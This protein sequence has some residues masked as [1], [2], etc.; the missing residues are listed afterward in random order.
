[1]SW[2]KLIRIRQ[3]P[4][5]LFVFAGLLFARRLADPQ[6]LLDSLTAFLLFCLAS[7]LVYV[8]NDLCDLNSDRLHPRKRKRPLASGSIRPAAAAW[9]AGIGLPLLAALTWW[10]LPE[11][12]WVLAAYL[13]L[14][15]VY[16]VRLKR[17]PVL[18]LFLVAA[19]FILRVLAGT[20]A[21]DV[22]ASDWVLLCTGSLALFLAAAKRRTE[23]PVDGDGRPTRA[24]EL[25]GP[26]FLDQV[27]SITAV[28]SILFYG[29]Y[30]SELNAGRPGGS[31]LMW[32]LP[33][34]VFGILHYLRLI[35]RNL[36]SGR[37]LLLDAPLIGTL[38]AWI[39]C[40]WIVLR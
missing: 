9:A 4:K 17:L 22:P 32:T 23:V 2:L 26:E 8:F 34:V 33:F 7:S 36:N 40:A 16:S 35:R 27:L 12:L 19:G 6:A 31:N 29:L 39:A 14:N 18:D 30:C 20:R 3:W 10:S 25:Y 28:S 13:A 1:M 11:I 21:L 5:N 37:T 15:I 38:I 24:R